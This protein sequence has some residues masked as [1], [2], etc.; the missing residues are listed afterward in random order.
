MLLLMPVGVL[1]HYRGRPGSRR[2]GAASPLKRTTTAAALL[3]GKVW[4]CVAR[5]K[6]SRLFSVNSVLRETPGGLERQGKV[7]RVQAVR[8]TRV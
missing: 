8:A 3:L 7:R 6:V 2:P 4:I 5:K 1:R